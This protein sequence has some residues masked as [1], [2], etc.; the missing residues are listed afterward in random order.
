MKEDMERLLA[1]I[2]TGEQFVFETNAN[3][4]YIF[5]ERAFGSIEPPA[6]GMIKSRTI[7]SYQ[8][9]VFFVYYVD[10]ERFEQVGGHKVGRRVVI[11]NPTITRE[12][13]K[14]LTEAQYETGILTSDILLNR[15]VGASPS[16]EFITSII[17][18]D[19][20]M[21]EF[22]HQFQEEI[23]NDEGIEMS[24]Q[25][26]EI[27]N[28]DPFYGLISNINLVRSHLK[29]EVST[30]GHTE[31]AVIIVAEILEKLTG[32]MLLVKENGEF[33]TPKEFIEILNRE[34][35]AEI[36]KTIT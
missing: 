8:N 3:G 5:T 2:D 20:E 14:L 15:V 29:G 27:V 17:N 12:I 18:A 30:R 24:S 28:A 9:K 23:T 7:L 26:A 4:L 21:H 34:D 10:A 32:E 11:F 16:L 36:F 25:L 31:A 35:I 6:S 1:M 22:Q 33:I 19:I 13:E